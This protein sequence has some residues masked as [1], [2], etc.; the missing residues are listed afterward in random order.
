M[1]QV[2]TTASEVLIQ[3]KVIVPMLFTLTEVPDL[4]PLLRSC[5]RPW[6]LIV[7]SYGFVNFDIQEHGPIASPCLASFSYQILFSHF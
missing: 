2:N 7:V 4:A 3:I 5:P 1:Y 6:G